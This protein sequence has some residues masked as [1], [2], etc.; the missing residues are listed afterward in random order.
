MKNWLEAFLVSDT[1][2]TT[3]LEVHDILEDSAIYAVIKTV[4]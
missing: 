4:Q 3:N 2:H 1:V